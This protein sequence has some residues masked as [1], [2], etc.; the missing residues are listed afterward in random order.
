M[1]ADTPTPDAQQPEQPTEQHEAP[2]PQDDA[3]APGEAV[4]P[5]AEAPREE[6]PE[7]P[8]PAP[9]EGAVPE[10]T[11]QE[12]ALREAV[13]FDD[14]LSGRFDAQAQ[15]PAEEPQAAAQAAPARQEAA[16]EESEQEEAEE[17]TA[18]PLAGSVKLHKA[19]AQSGY[20]SRF[21]MEQWI[22]D[23]R[24][25]VNGEVAHVGQRI[26][27]SDRITLD[28][29]AVRLRTGSPAPRVLAYHKPA[30]EVVTHDDPAGRPTVFRALPHLPA[31]QGK[32]Q[33]VGRLDLNTEGLLLLTNS[34]ALA[35]R[36]MHPRFGLEREYAV[37]VLGALSDEE[38]QRL[39][40]GVELDDGPAR[41]NCIQAEGASNESANQWYRV[42]ISEGRNREVRRMIE[43][44]GHAVSRLIRIRYGAVRLP[45]G[46]RRGSFIELSAAEVR[47]LV[48][49]SGAGEGVLHAAPA[50]GQGSKP[51][52]K[53]G[54]NA[55]QRRRKG[56]DRAAGSGPRPSR[57]KPAP[58][59]RRASRG[60]GGERGGSRRE[61]FWDADGEAFA[62]QGRRSPRGAPQRKSGQRSSAPRSGYRARI[63]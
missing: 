21:E 47:A 45:R 40:A 46:L 24:V 38:Q 27:A 51:G 12:E 55:P 18:A 16:Q 29:R 17:A 23:G 3:A 14:L 59:D 22:A 42:A 60:A 53:Q 26:S 61:A 5:A 30:G 37:R 43:A 63:S 62:P 28:G 39:L 36:L 25:A 49:A 15:Q 33:S 44:L 13:S 2:A 10:T 48:H 52:G 4:A 50:A 20:G 41:F 9:E 6:T 19:L 8:A 35:N 7:P 1:N 58:N 32:W 34:G 57:P 54:G 31:I 56:A 11:P